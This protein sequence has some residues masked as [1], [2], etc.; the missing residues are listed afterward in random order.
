MKFLF[1]E[2]ASRLYDFLMFPKLLYVDPEQ[3][4]N[5]NEVLGEGGMEEFAT[6]EAYMEFVEAAKKDLEPFK[7]PL[8]GFYADESIS[9]YDFPMLLFKAYSFLGFNDYRSY[10]QSIMKDEEDVIRTNLIHAL[11]T[12][13]KGEKETDEKQARE[14]AEHLRKNRDDLFKIVRGTPTT[15]NHRWVLILLVESPK[16]YLGFYIDLLE[17][18]HSI[19]KKYLDQHEPKLKRFKE[20][21]VTPLRQEGETAFQELTQDIIP[22]EVLN[23]ENILITSFTNPYFYTGL[24]TGEDL[25]ILFGADMKTGFLKIAEFRDESRKNRAKVFKTLSEE[26]RY[27]VLR[28]IARGMTS[29][30]AI[31]NEI[32]ISS[33]TVTYHIN[34]F[35]T[36]KVIKIPKTKEARKEA[37]YVVDFERLESFWEAFM[38]E[39]KNGQV[40]V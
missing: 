9:N 6:H 28:L 26:T 13:E 1:D 14:K 2:K 23:E 31:A 7:D 24:T 20:E 3:L 30:K 8:L 10:L 18:V 11:L 4:H 39:L 12:V 21:V 35:L 36:A 19:F 27:E 16:E 37:R 32:G 34:A 15:E 25:I 5:L 17:E 40:I 22:F 33:A 38:N 29:T